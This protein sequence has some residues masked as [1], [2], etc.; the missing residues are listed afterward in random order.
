[1]DGAPGLYIGAQLLV[2]ACTN[3]GQNSWCLQVQCSCIVPHTVNSTG[4]RY[5]RISNT[6]PQTKLRSPDQGSSKDAVCRGRSSLLVPAESW[7]ECQPSGL[8]Y[9]PS[10]QTNLLFHGNLGH[11][12]SSHLS[13]SSRVKTGDWQPHGRRSDCLPTTWDAMGRIPSPQAVSSPTSTHQQ[14]RS[15]Q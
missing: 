15:S 3:K 12:N 9:Q 5:T 8:W 4:E 1:M 7:S 2:I 11:S 13:S 6:P 10:P 14:W